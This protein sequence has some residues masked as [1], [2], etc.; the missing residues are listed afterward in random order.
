MKSITILFF[1]Q[2]VPRKTS[3][4]RPRP[5]RCLDIQQHPDIVRASLRWAVDGNRR[6][7]EGVGE[8]MGGW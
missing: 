8:L 2:I 3:F 7:A 5:Q 4:H 1:P 6:T